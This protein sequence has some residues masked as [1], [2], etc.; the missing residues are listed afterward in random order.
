MT[1]NQPGNAFPAEY[2]FDPESKD[3]T[4]TLPETGE[5]APIVNAAEAAPEPAA[6]TE[7]SPAEI[8]KSRREGVSR[9]VGNLKERFA[10]TAV[11]KRVGK[12]FGGIRAFSGKLLNF[13]SAPDAYAKRGLENTKNFFRDKK[14]RLANFATEKAE[15]ARELIELTSDKGVEK[16]EEIMTKIAA[17]YEKLREH[18][19][20]GIDAGIAKI[21][22]IREDMRDRKRQNYE[23]NLADLRVKY[24]QEA[25]V[26]LQKV[27]Q[28]SGLLGLQQRITL[29]AL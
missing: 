5:V 28:I 8:A 9:F 19:E 1:T 13:A 15:M 21:R 11:G 23:R 29:A 18:G 12:I 27:N 7:Q 20:D 24:M 4:V 26:K 17:R 22:S 6:K 2:Y 16:F 14:D 10:N 3:A 25:G